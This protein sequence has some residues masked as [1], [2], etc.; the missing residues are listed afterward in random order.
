MY[1]HEYGFRSKHSTQQAIIELA[2]KTTSATQQ[3]NELTIANFLD[4]SAFETV[5]HKISHWHDSNYGLS[6]RQKIL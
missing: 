1:D 2:D 5:D 3:N 4:L 6:D